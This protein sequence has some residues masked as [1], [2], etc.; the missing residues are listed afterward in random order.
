MKHVVAESENGLD[1]FFEC[2]SS[3]FAEDSLSKLERSE[4]GSQLV[5]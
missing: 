2:F 3:G 5:F 4:V 1:D